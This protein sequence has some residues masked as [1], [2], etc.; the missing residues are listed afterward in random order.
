M[1]MMMLIQYA[2]KKDNLS[3]KRHEMNKYSFSDA[4]LVA[5]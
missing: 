3:S 1:K 5:E 4:S 2:E